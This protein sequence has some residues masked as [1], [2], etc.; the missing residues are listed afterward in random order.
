MNVVL[1]GAAR[2]D[3]TRVGVEV[4]RVAEQGG[5]IAVVRQLLAQRTADLPDAERPGGALVQQWLEHVARRAV[6]QR[7]IDDV[8]TPQPAS[9]EQAAESAPDD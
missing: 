8:H 1:V 6:E 5:H 3:A 7:D 4:D 9:A 2:V